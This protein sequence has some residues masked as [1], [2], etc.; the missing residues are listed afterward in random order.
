MMQKLSLLI[1]GLSFALL[2]N[3][4][5]TQVQYKRAISGISDE[6]HK[7]VLPDDIYK[8][9]GI[10]TSLHDFRIVGITAAKDTVEA[11]YVLNFNDLEE[12][13]VQK[14]CKIINESYDGKTYYATLAMPTA[15]EFNTIGLDFSQDNFDWQLK[16][17]GSN[18]NNQW[19]NV[20][21]NYRIIAI[22]NQFVDYAYSQLNISPS[23]YMYFRLSFNTPTRPQLNMATLGLKTAPQKPLK[24]FTLTKMQVFENKN[25]KYTEVEFEIKNRVPVSAIRIKIKDQFDFYRPLR[26]ECL[27]DSFKTDKGWQYSYKDVLGEVLNSK[28]DNNFNFA[29]T[30]AKKFKIKIYNQDNQP[31]QIQSLAAA[32]Y[33][34]ELL[35]R[36][37]EKANYYLVYGDS[38]PT[39]PDY[40]LKYFK[41]QLPKEAKVLNLGNEEIANFKRGSVVKPLISNKWWLWGLM[42]LLIL[43][44]GGF[45]LKMMKQ[46]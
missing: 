43:V 35:V 44:L 42:G 2:A 3:A 13:I 26:I 7:I 37:T 30:F 24:K 25:E 29:R 11:P 27:A 8:N 31:L 22:K 20:E 36:F 16:V 15:E 6:W 10:N 18:N 9:G 34:H 23:K 5:K 12:Y 32:G 19:F 40:D 45:T 21:D 46:V 17:E 38:N 1:F 33:S 14:E 4:Q 39:T 28:T 41:D